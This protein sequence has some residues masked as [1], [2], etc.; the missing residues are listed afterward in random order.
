M[1]QSKIET[2]LVVQ[3]YIYPPHYKGTRVALAMVVKVDGEEV[4]SV[5]FLSGPK[6]EVLA[7]KAGEMSLAEVR[8]AWKHKK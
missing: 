2:E 7:F 1:S 3:E 6:E 5:S 8:K 4:G